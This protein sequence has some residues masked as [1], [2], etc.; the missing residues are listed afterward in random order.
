MENKI[1]DVI[2]I[3]NDYNIQKLKEECNIIMNRPLDV[4]NTNKYNMIGWDKY[5]LYLPII[6]NNHT[7]DSSITIDGFTDLTFKPTNYL[8]NLPYIKEIINSFNTKIYYSYISKLR[9]WKK[10]DKH[11]DIDSGPT[12]WLNIEK[13]IRLH[14]PIITN[15]K[16]QFFIGDPTCKEYYLEEGHLYYIRAGDKP[17]YVENNSNQDRYHLI[18]DLKPT[19]DLLDKIMFKIK[20]QRLLK[21]YELVSLGYSCYPKFII[22]EI[23]DKE[24]NFFDWVASSTWS[25]LNLL[26]NNF[27]NV[28][29]ENNYHYFNKQFIPH[30][31][32]NFIY[33]KEYYL[34]F[35][36]DDDF[37]KNTNEWNV[38]QSKYTR[39]I[40]RFKNL[41]K[42]TNDVLFFYLEENLIR[43]DKLYPEIEKY[44]PKNNENYH[45]EQSKL[46]Q[47]RMHD[48]VKTI[49]TKYNKHN[50]KIMYFSHLVDKTH[51][52]DNIIFI[53]TDCHY[54]QFEWDKVARN[55]GIK[56]IIDNY[57][58]INDILNNNSI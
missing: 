53:K 26:D 12:D 37:L 40:D 36:H 43:F 49:K 31:P 21:N 28:L 7:T 38:F 16:V 29:N 58:Y 35:I 24:T 22:R 56:S 44:Y 32:D 48:I 18:I 13:V 30:S 34:R 51:Y 10:I 19:P 6:D 1:D 2:L 23:I 15:P 11:K 57:D 54:N 45:I 39:R 5:P 50:F 17:H 27:N 25:I 4:I 14:I 47:S 20:L 33:N 8:D 52:K 41:L 55:H 3:K 46:E 42:S 9:A